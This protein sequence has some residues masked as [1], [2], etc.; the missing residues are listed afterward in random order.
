[1]GVFAVLLLTALP[2]HAAAP[3]DVSAPGFRRLPGMNKSDATA[4]ISTGRHNPHYARI[5]GYQAI[6]GAWPVPTFT[7]VND[8]SGDPTIMMQFILSTEPDTTGGT[9]PV[10]IYPSVSVTWT[11]ATGQPRGFLN[12]TNFDIG[13]LWYE[14]DDPDLDGNTAEDVPDTNFDGNPG[15]NPGWGQRRIALA[16]DESYFWQVNRWSPDGF[17]AGPVW[18]FQSNKAPNVSAV[19]S[20]E[21]GAGN[22]GTVESYTSSLTDPFVIFSISD[23]DTPPTASTQAHIARAHFAAIWLVDK[24]DPWIDPAYVDDN[25]FNANTY[26]VTD[27]DFTYWWNPSSVGRYESGQDPISGGALD[28]SDMADIDDLA[29]PFFIANGHYRIAL[30]NHVDTTHW[31]YDPSTYYTVRF[32]R[33]SDIEANQYE[34]PDGNV[35]GILDDTYNPNYG[36]LAWDNPLQYQ[37]LMPS[38]TDLH[39]GSRSWYTEPLST[40]TRTME[41]NGKRRPLLKDKDYVWRIRVFDGDLFSE[42]SPSA[43]YFP[44]EDPRGGSG[45]QYPWQFRTAAND[46][47]ETVYKPYPPDYRSPRT[48]MASAPPPQSIHVTSSPPPTLS[49]VG[50]EP[51]GDPVTYDVYFGTETEP[52]IVASG[53]TQAK[54]TP[55]ALQ[56]NKRYYWYVVTRDQFGAT[57]RSE[58]FSQYFS[59]QYPDRAN[60]SFLANNQPPSVPGSGNPI[61]PEPTDYSPPVPPTN[62]VDD[63]PVPD[64]SASAHGQGSLHQLLSWSSTDPEDDT[65]YYDVYFSRPHDDG[66]LADPEPDNNEG[67]SELVAFRTTDTSWEPPYALEAGRIY[68]W[69]IV[70]YNVVEDT[71]GNNI[72]LKAD[73]ISS[74]T[75]SFVAVN[76][77]PTAPADPTPVN[78]PDYPGAT[79]PAALISVVTELSWRCTDADLDPI[80]YTVEVDEAPDTAPGV[81]VT[82]VGLTSSSWAIAG[83]SSQ[84]WKAQ[85]LPNTWYKWTV[86]AADSNGATAIGGPWYFRTGYQAPNMPAAVFPLH[87]ALTVNPSEKKIRWDCTHPD[88]VPL[89]FDVYYGQGNNPPVVSAGHTAK[90]V[91]AAADGGDDAEH[92]YWLITPVLRPETKYFWRIVAKDGLNQVASTLF[93]FTTINRPPQPPTPIYPPHNAVSVI[94]P[95]IFQWDCVDQDGDKLTY[96]FYF[97]A[98]ANPPVVATALDVGTYGGP[99]GNGVD[100]QPNNTYYWRIEASD[101]HGN[102]VSSDADPTTPGNQAWKFETNKPPNEPTNFK[103]ADGETDVVPVPPPRL[104][105]DGSDP[106]NDALTYEVYFGEMTPPPL[107]SSG[108]ADDYY[109]PTSNLKAKTVYYWQIVARDSV[110]ARTQ[111]PVLSFTTGNLPPY[112]PT[113][114]D[115]PDGATGVGRTPKLTWDAT[116]PEGGTLQFDVYFGTDRDNLELRAQGRP[117][118]DYLPGSLEE[119]QT[120]YWKVVS[121]DVFGGSTSGPIWSFTTRNDPPTDPVLV[122][123]QNGSFDIPL[124]GVVLQ[125]ISSDPEGFPITYDV[126]FG[127]PGSLQKLATDQSESTYTVPNGTTVLRLKSLTLY[128]WYVVA[129][130]RKGATTTSSTWSF[131]TENNRPFA[132]SDPVPPD[133]AVGVVPITLEWQCYDPADPTSGESDPDGDDVVFDVYLSTVDPGVGPMSD[134]DQIGTGVGASQLAV[135]DLQ[136]LTTYY[137]QV[138]SRDVHGASSYGPIWSFT[139]PDLFDITGNLSQG[140]GNAVG[141]VTVELRDGSGTTLETTTSDANG[142]YAFLAF[143]AGDY[144]IVPTSYDWTFAPPSADLT[145]GPDAVQDFIA[146]PLLYT[147]SGTV[148]DVSGDPIQGVQVRVLPG[149]NLTATTAADGTYTVEN[150]PSGARQV[151]GVHL[152]YTFEPTMTNVGLPVNPPAE[153]NATGIDFVGTPVVYTMS[154]TVYDF[155]DPAQPLAGV[156]VQATR[157]GEASPAA[158]TVT[159]DTGAYTLTDLTYG[160]YEVG[161]VLA[162]FTFKDASA[163]TAP[164]DV[165]LSGTTGD[166]TGID[167]YQDFVAVPTVV[168]L[169]PD[170]LTIE[171]RGTASLTVAVRDQIGDGIEGIDITVNSTGSSIIPIVNQTVTTNVAGQAQISVVATP[172]TLG[173]ATI[174]VELADTPTLTDSAAITVAWQISLTPPLGSRDSYMIAVPASFDP[175]SM[176]P[177]PDFA[178]Y[179]SEQGRYEAYSAG[180]FTLGPGQGYIVHVTADT[181]LSGSEGSLFDT[182]DDLIVPLGYGWTLLGNPRLKDLTWSLANLKV[183]SGGTTMTLAQ[184]V[185]NGLIEP[186]GWSWDPDTDQ[187]LFVADD[188]LFA[189]ANDVLPKYEAMWIR[190]LAVGLAMEFPAGTAG[191]SAAA[192]AVRGENDWLARIIARGGT[193]VDRENYFGVSTAPLA[194]GGLRVS[195]PPPMGEAAESVELSFIPEGDAN[196]LAVDIRDAQEE[197]M[198]WHGRVEALGVSGLVT[199]SWDDLKQ[200]PRDYIVTLEDAQTGKRTSMRTATSYLFEA[201]A[202]GATIREFTLTVE[203]RISAGLQVLLG[204]PSVR[205]R[206]ATFEAA[207]QY[208][209]TRD[210]NV[211]CVVRNAAGR[212]IR[213]L[214]TTEAAA[215]VNTLSWNGATDAGAAVPAGQYIVEIQATSDDGQKAKAIRTIQR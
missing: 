51:N 98:S 164:I 119:A 185:T 154:G 163:K 123:P 213:T 23:D 173:P 4:G 171:P 125:W 128:Q 50:D 84:R 33:N 160:T 132:P 24:R 80:T 82:K 14:G 120:Y 138:K 180:N 25:A 42:A 54:Y 17:N 133:G 177:R 190:T 21:N 175:G 71:S 95:T 16:S 44:F 127:E 7:W 155:Q 117:T 211:E 28:G 20:P 208:T 27:F 35:P 151:T 93:E 193:Q 97:G 201:N 55:P 139:T 46:P 198:V 37:M 170:A 11:F 19:L 144:T 36:S 86:T 104:E 110:G 186:Y 88:G 99:S 34:Q 196:R 145:L 203:R 157:T 102:T 172:G 101:G 112:V 59:L 31:Y 72:V 183:Q 161:P 32:G 116:D 153:T 166:L 48:E 107:V 192:T 210:A 129:R 179:L 152:E 67:D 209:L 85:L 178:R 75:W 134:T 1:M 92:F 187:Y 111:G 159:D 73:M 106:E 70:A 114:P 56:S 206:G 26:E 49:W 199:L 40:R 126:Y 60:W 68:Y 118:R 158:E 39:P 94:H 81:D 122:N 195:S 12:T 8:D 140:G 109:T 83:E 149:T 137:W 174:S 47:P 188:S 184:A 29:G 150:V 91:W 200:I 63:D 169:T 108:Q 130:D 41:L 90:E 30:N 167:F 53:L 124:V 6:R 121:K 212:V 100:T 61:D 52:P 214:P 2:V 5:S 215:G 131:T 43:G 62:L 96:S 18:S 74:P 64:A 205:S 136:E 13:N 197:K 143:P 162:P 69:R 79:A 87:K 113:N 165:V 58:S 147:I 103:P 38:R 189:G 194:R 141:G 45:W 10:L 76:V 15:P 168:E 66:S 148:A 115:P 77:P 57:Q 202:D 78:N 182:G 207:L 89:T 191:A 142:D 176:S 65:V 181:V 22:V 3:K 9:E 204:E 146:V 135:P 105:W 156:P